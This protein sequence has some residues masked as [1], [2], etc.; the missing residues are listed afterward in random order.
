MY[1]DAPPL[2][3]SEY[4][5]FLE[6]L[7]NFGLADLVKS[8]GDRGGNPTP[9]GF[10]HKVVSTSPWARARANFVGAEDPKPYFRTP[11]EQ[12]DIFSGS[13]ATAERVKWAPR[14]G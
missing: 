4:W 9:P 6:A 5:A 10:G 7:E 3:G 11:L 2:T 12:R 1:R 13:G 8:T 14:G